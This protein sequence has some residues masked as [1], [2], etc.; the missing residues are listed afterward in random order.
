VSQQGGSDVRACSIHRRVRELQA[1][2]FS[3]T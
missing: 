1:Q 3:N 2:F